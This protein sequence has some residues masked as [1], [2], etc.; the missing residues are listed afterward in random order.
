[1]GNA[2]KLQLKVEL[3]FDD[4]L[5]LLDQLSEEQKIAFFEKLR[6]EVFRGKIK[7]LAAE[8]PSP[9]LSEEEIVS[10]IS[11]ARQT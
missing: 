11:A 1:M 7:K 10:E 3:S 4:M 6:L 5:A 8:I 2:K 9:G